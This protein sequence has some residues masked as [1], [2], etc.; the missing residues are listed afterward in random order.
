MRFLN[1]TGVVVLGALGCVYT[2]DPDNARWIPH[3]GAQQNSLAAV[4]QGN[5]KRLVMVS[6]NANQRGA[7]ASSNLK[8]LGGAVLTN[9]TSYALWW[10][11]PGNWPGDA[12]MGIN[13]FL[14]GLDGSAYLAITD[15]YLGA[16]ART[17]FAGNLFDTYAPPQQSPSTEEVVGEVCKVLTA[18]RIAPS[19]NGL[20]MVFTD[21]FPNQNQF[22]AWHD[23][24]RCPDGT[25]I[26]VAY[27]PNA[28]GVQGCDPGNQLACNNL[29]QGTRALANITAHELLEMVTD[30]EGDA[31]RD[32]DGEEIADKCVWMFQSCV[33]LR[34]GQWQLQEE[35]SNGASGC[36]QGATKA[37]ALAR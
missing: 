35:W 8:D 33:A 15:Q 3:A 9:T 21:N 5:F 22:C 23:A 19:P 12:M 27:L 2:P 29:S 4:R 25:T 13:T 28:T 32:A 18:N 1:W 30:P 10:G 14:G 26:H 31:W 6:R 36:V 37:V 17:Q 16:Q 24:G 34:G 11:S 20:Y 7:T